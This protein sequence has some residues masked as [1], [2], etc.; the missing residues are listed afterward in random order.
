MASLGRNVKKTTT[1]TTG[2]ASTPKTTST[3]TSTPKTTTTSTPSSTS[4]SGGSSI[5]SGITNGLS[6]LANAIKTNSTT[7]EANP[8]NTTSTPTYNTSNSGSASYMNQAQQLA[9]Q[10][11]IDNNIFYEIQKKAENNTAMY[12]PT[13]GK[14]AVYNALQNYF[15]SEIKNKAQSGV[16][17]DSS[18]AWKNSLYNSYLNQNSTPTT[19]TPNFNESPEYLAMQQQIQDLLGRKPDT[20]AYDEMIA[21]QNAQMQAMQKLIEEMQAKQA[22][23]DSL[24]VPSNPIQTYSNVYTPGS[25]SNS[26]GYTDNQL[27]TNNLFNQYLN[28]IYKG[29]F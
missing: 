27:V 28:S 8:G 16:A 26:I 3:T 6:S 23:Q 12:E 13:E 18:N 14:N 17:L 2:T 19:T 20:S 25:S 21:N 4:S 1:S 10:Y 11:G 15:A 9:K 24:Y 5:I 7:R 22:Y 29:G